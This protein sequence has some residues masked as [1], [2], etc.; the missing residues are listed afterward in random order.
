MLTVIFVVAGSFYLI[1]AGDGS[2]KREIKRETA[3][4]ALLQKDVELRDIGRK[5]EKR[6]AL[7]QCQASVCP[8]NGPGTGGG[9]GNQNPSC[10]SLGGAKIT[11]DDSNCVDIVESSV[12]TFDNSTGNFT[13][14][15]TG[16]AECSQEDLE[17]SAILYVTRRGCERMKAI[18][19]YLRYI[20]C[21][22]PPSQGTFGAGNASED[23]QSHTMKRSVFPPDERKL[24][25]NPKQTFP[26]SA[27][28]RISNGCTGTFIGPKHVL[29]AGHC[30]YNH[31]SQRWYSHLDIWRAKYCDPDCGKFHKWTLA[32]TVKGWAMFG[33]PAYDYALIVV[34]HPSPVKMLIGYWKPIPM[35]VH[36]NIAGYPT[37][38]SGNCMWRAF[39]PVTARAKFQLGH[40]CD[41]FN[42]MSGSPVYTFWPA[43]QNRH[44]VHC[45]H[46][47]GGADH[48]SCTRIT[49]FRL[50]QIVRWIATF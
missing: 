42:G 2:N 28:A 3:E 38:L 26:W 30:V 29:T 23:M 35:G 12:T 47:Y 16:I 7:L 32:I 44:I 43:E 25:I 11:F 10:Q 39:C 18:P 33:L 36:V 9:G 8:R 41:T 27:I 37:D 4:E 50:T 48:N 31:T 6:S 1:R 20:A 13:D 17:K 45:V 34:D 14:D 40:S 15:G 46:A 24:V 19:R 5:I 22:G 49:R 21:N